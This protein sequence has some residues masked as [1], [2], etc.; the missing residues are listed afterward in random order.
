M[1]AAQPSALVLSCLGA[2]LL[3]TGS[4]VSLAQPDN[5]KTQV[6]NTGRASTLEKRSAWTSSRI[7]GSPEPPSPYRTERIFPKLKWVEPLEMVALPGSDRFVLAEH[8]GKIY[9]FPNDPNCESADVFADMK[10]WK[11]EIQEV[12]SVTFHP[13]FEKNRYVYIWYILKP[14]LPDGTRISRFKVIETNPPKVDLSTEHV[15]ITWKSGGHNGGCARFGKDGMLY[16]ATGDGVGPAP[17]DTLN[18]GQDISDL[19]S[20]ILRIDV[21]HESDGRGYRVPL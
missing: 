3:V 20:S 8:A 10:Q 13:Q 12:Y 1:K 19:L 9:S 11:P 7:T 4:L 6:S 21:D 17:P 18:T 14:E 15:A 5:L 2:V 16:I